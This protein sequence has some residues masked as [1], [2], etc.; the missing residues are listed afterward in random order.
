MWISPRNVNRIN[1]LMGVV[2]AV[3]AVVVCLR[4]PVTFLTALTVVS[5]WQLWPRGCFKHIFAPPRRNALARVRVR[6]Q[7]D[8]FRME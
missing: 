5:V 8:L 6:P 7:A 4:A 1:L 2:L 3:A